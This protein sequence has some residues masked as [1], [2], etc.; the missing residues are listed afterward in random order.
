MQ[1]C[2]RL[3]LE[4]LT[5]QHSVSRLGLDQKY[6]QATRSFRH[7]MVYNE[8]Q[9]TKRVTS[10]RVQVF[11]YPLGPSGAVLL[12]QLAVDGELGNYKYLKT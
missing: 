3:L 11:A 9:R 8:Y 1:L 6:V 7:K 10:R 12:R 4:L 5:D 2:T